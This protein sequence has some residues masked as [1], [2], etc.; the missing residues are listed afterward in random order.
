MHSDLVSLVLGLR[1]CI[2]NNKL[3]GDASASGPQLTL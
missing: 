3:P 2:S 1:F